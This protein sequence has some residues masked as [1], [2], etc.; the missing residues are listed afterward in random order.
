MS[1]DILAKASL[2]ERGH[3]ARQEMTGQADGVDVV[4]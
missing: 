1:S 3:A 2:F 4:E